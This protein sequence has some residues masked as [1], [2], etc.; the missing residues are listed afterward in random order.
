[1]SLA[2]YVEPD[3]EMRNFTTIYAFN[4]YQADKHMVWPWERI[5]CL[6]VTTAHTWHGLC[7]TSGLISPASLEETRVYSWSLPQ[8]HVLE[9]PVGWYLWMVS[10]VH[11]A[12]EHADDLAAARQLSST[13]REA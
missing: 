3:G 9:L 13:S 2:G 5:Q 11:A 7:T 12:V 4:A 1:M 8:G 10:L 6:A